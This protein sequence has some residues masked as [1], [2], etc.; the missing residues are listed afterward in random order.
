MFGEGALENAKERVYSEICS[1]EGLTRQ[2]AAPAIERY[3]KRLGVLVERYQS[4]V[5]K[6]A[7]R[8]QTDI[9]AAVEQKEEAGN[10]SGQ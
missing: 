1:K 6:A 7:I 2:E 4:G 10:G 5:K 3:E 8:L 9:A